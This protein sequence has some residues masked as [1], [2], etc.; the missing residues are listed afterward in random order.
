MTECFLL[1][2]PHSQA[3]GR[4]VPEPGRRWGSQGSLDPAGAPPRC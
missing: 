2:C 3:E 1:R 4:L